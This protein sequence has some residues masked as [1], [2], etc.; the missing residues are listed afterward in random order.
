MSSSSTDIPLH[1][2]GKVIINAQ[3]FAAPGQADKVQ[4]H[5]AA[6]RRHALSDKEPGC[7]EYRTIRSFVADGAIK[8][9]VF[10]RPRRT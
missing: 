7:L 1:A 8:F 5:L 9:A 3:L 2:K 4:E 6:I 10:D